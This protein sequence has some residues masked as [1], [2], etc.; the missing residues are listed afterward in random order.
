MM[1]GENQADAQTNSNRVRQASGQ[2]SRRAETVTQ[3]PHKNLRRSLLYPIAA[4]DARH[5]SWC[6]ALVSS[7]STASCTRSAMPSSGLLIAVA[8]PVGDVVV[9]AWVLVLG[10]EPA[11][12]L[13]LTLALVPASCNR[14]KFSSA[15]SAE[16]VVATA[17]VVSAEV[18]RERVPV[19]VS[20]PLLPCLPV[21]LP[22]K[23]PVA[24]AE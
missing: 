10:V 6:R 15:G 9:S 22:V 5:S 18:D 20:K 8:L 23:M 1:A 12:V 2:N 3:T 24:G 4:I 19:A 13:P 7:R 17:A 11:I 14:D 21:P 16:V